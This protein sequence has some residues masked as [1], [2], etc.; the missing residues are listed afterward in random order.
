MPKAVRFNRFA[1][2]D[3]LEFEEVADRRP[4][5]GEVALAVE[6]VALNRPESTFH[7]GEYT[8]QPQLQIGLSCE[9]VGIVSAV[10]PGV[11]SSL[12][13][14]RAGTVSVYSMS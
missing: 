6:A 1:Q 12:V 13:G 11:D 9:A 10:G 14:T 5:V 3:V 4:E 8:G 7:P 2:A